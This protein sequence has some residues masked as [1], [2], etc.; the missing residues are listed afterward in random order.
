MSDRLVA[1][2]M[3]RLDL[4]RKRGA[5]DPFN[6]DSRPTPKQQQVIEDFGLI[7]QQWIRAGNQSG[8][9]ATCARLVSWV[10]TDTHPTWKR[11]DE[12]LS[13]PLL[14]IVAG[15][16]GKQIEDS[17]LPK[18]RGFLEPGTYKEVRIGNIIQ[19]LELTNG[20]R[21]IFQ[22]LENPNTARERLQ[23]Y[24]AH[25]TWCDELPPDMEIV[26]E[27]LIR[28]Q[29]RNGY[30]LFSFTPTVMNVDIQRYV[31]SLM[32]PEAR[33][34]RFHMLDNPLY[35]D[36][37]R[38]KELLD[39]YSHLP[40]D[41]QKM[42]FEGEW[43]SSDSQVYYFNYSKMVE[44][45]PDYSPLWRHVESVDPALKSALGLTI[46]A[47]NPKTGV[48]Y[49]IVA[50]YIKGIYVPTELV[51]HVK[52]LTSRYNIVRR[53]ADPHEVWYI[54][55]AGSLGIHY[56]GVYKKNERKAELIK[57]LQESLSNGSSKISPEC[58]HFI[59]ELQECRYSDRADGKIVNGP[60]YH[61]LDSAQ[62]FNDNKPKAEAVGL[63]KA[64]SWDDWLYQANEK[65]KAGIEKTKDK[66]ERAQLIRRGIRKGRQTKQGIS[67]W[68]Q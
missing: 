38:K 58:Q 48:W 66:I 21:V 27:L 67:A 10:V 17:L 35:S 34:Y 11:P 57:G 37:V 7:K 20:N 64:G 1:A 59:Q 60:S 33:V 65:R 68:K 36:E 55:T 25:L 47:E 56:I 45:P 52:S 22:S 41:Q 5:F 23:S 29:A 49:C 46:W 30:S 44:M 6:L 2:A 12:W 53:I 28:V 4:L 61:I 24:V 40:A 31:D 13:E 26:R 39:R 8:K 19:R 18:I 43:I 15:R 63:I 54:Q 51:K 32:E 9:S 14:V 62:Y 3:S 42:I 16:T 50:E